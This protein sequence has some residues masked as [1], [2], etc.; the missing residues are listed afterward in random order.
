[1][2]T[3]KENNGIPVEKFVLKCYGRKVADEKWYGVCLNL[4]LAVEADSLQEMREKMKEVISCYLEAVIETDDKDS[5]PDLLFR[6][7]PVSDW[8]IYYLFCTLDFITKFPKNILFKEF[9]PFHL[10]HSC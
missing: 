9:I 1:M 10:A 5:I 7:A 4:N 3:L 2:D 6:P 8:L